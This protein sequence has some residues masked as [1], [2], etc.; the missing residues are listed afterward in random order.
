MRKAEEEV[1]SLSSD[2]ID[3]NGVIDAYMTLANFCDSHLCKEGSAGELKMN[4]HFSF[5]P[6]RK[7]IGGNEYLSPNSY[8]FISAF[9]SMSILLK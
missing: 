4:F 2:H 6:L 8:I 1:Q 3:I 9:T 5:A 7:Q